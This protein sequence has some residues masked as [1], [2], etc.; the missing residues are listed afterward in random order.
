MRLLL[1]R[2][3]RAGASNSRG[4]LFILIV[5]IFAFGAAVQ[6]ARSQRQ[7]KKMVDGSPIEIPSGS[8]VPAPADMIS[9]WKAEGNA[10]DSQDSNNGTFVGNGTFGSGKVGQA[11]NFDGS[12]YVE[13]PNSPSL[14][15][16]PL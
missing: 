10:N 7:G 5:A 13:V 2:V 6:S 15:P 16:A 1:Q 8:C 11:F 9:W 14:N 4:A 12:S 3:R